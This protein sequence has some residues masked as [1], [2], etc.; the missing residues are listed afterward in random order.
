MSWQC[1]F[2]LHRSVIFVVIVTF[3]VVVH[4]PNFSL[5]I[6]AAIVTA[7]V[8]VGIQS[9]PLM[10]KN[11]TVGKIDMLVQVAFTAD[12]LFKI[13]SEGCRPWSFW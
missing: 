2:S 8:L 3:K 13:M 6:V 9:Y 5:L 10:A 7:G 11:P 4:D 12:C 1:Y